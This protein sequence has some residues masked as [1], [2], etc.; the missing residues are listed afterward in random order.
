MDNTICAVSF[1]LLS[2]ARSGLGYRHRRRRLGLVLLFALPA[3]AQK[4]STLE[5]YGGYDYVRYN[6]TPRETGAPLSESF[7][8]NGVS[9]QIVYN[10]NTWLGLLGELGGYALARR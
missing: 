6:A 3:T 9:C 1:I 8:A 7:N 5:S 10:P 4:A 2:C